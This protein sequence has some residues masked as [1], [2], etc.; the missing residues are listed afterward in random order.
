MV[1]YPKS[2]KPRRI[3]CSTTDQQ[4]ELLTALATVI[5]AVR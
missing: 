4:R 1:Y 3:L 5:P 2:T